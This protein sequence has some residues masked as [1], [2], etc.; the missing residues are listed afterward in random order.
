VRD[1]AGAEGSEV[2]GVAALLRWAGEIGGLE[3]RV[4]ADSAADA[5]R[6]IRAGA[7]GVGLCRIEHMLLGDR[8]RLLERLLVVPPGPQATQ[9][10]DQLRELLRADFMAILTAMDGRPVAVRLLDPPRHEFLPDP[11]GSAAGTARGGDRGEF[12][13]VAGGD[14]R[15]ESAGVAG[16]DS[17]GELAG[18]GGRGGF[19]GVVGADG[20]GTSA[21]AGGAGGW[22]EAA[23]VAGGDGRGTSAGATGAGDR[24]ESAGGGDRRLSG[25]GSRAAAGAG[26]LGERHPML[27]VRGVRLN[28]LRMDL[29]AAQIQALV[30]ATA[31]V[32]RAGGAP[33]PELLVPMVSTPAE[34]DPIRRLLLDTVRLAGRAASKSPIPV[35]AMIETPRAALLAGELAARVDFFSIGTNDLTAL[36]WGLS[37]DDAESQLLPAY[38]DLGI[39]GRSPFR[40]L[41]IDGVGALLRQA[42]GAAR[43]VNPRMP[44]GV[45][46]EH[47]ASA[48]AASFLARIGVDYVSCATAL[49]PV[50]RLACARAAISTEER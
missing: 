25:F 37:R 36:V 8:K 17:R 12:A 5:L 9:A 15:G 32:R 26:G 20:R 11:A 19:V 22:G 35:G 7:T 45:C 46:G 28:L 2:D 16:D 47:A 24:G 31:A 14:D 13:E 1:R 34:I 33:R 21:G 40:D 38:R 42:T 30:E 23:G 3:V 43:A 6:G 10:L 4:N 27:G 50:A 49:V 44:I 29:A 41:D 48:R 39:V 18:A